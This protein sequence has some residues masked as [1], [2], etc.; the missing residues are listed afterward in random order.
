M[1]HSPENWHEI[2][3]QLQAAAQRKGLTQTD[4]QERTGLLQTNISR[5]FLRKYAPNIQTLVILAD[6]IGVE[7]RIVEKE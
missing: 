3:D 7:I 6:A 5:I 4:L 2:V 1:K